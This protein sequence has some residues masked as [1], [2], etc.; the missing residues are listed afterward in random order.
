MN[1]KISLIALL[2]VVFTSFSYA[3]KST[4]DPV[5]MTI[6]GKP[7]TKSQFL[8]VYLKNNDHPKYDKK[9]LDKY[10]VLYKKFRLKVAEAEAEKYDTLPSLV[11]E[12]AKYRNELAQ[13]YL[14][15]TAKMH[16]LMHEAYNRMKQEVRASHIMIS[17]KPDASPEDTL[18]A[19]NKI[20]SIRKKVIDGA[21]FG[22][23]AQQ[24]SDDPSAKKNKGDLGYFSAFQMVY[25]FESAA[26]NTPIG[27]IS[28]PVRSRFGYHI[29]KVVAKRP[30]RGTI[31]VAHIMI[32]LAKGATKGEVQEANKKIDEIY[33]KLQNG[34]DFAKLAKLYSDDKSSKNNGGQ[35]APFG[36]G[37]NRRMVPVFEEMAYSLKKD[38]DYSKPFRSPY[39]F[40][41][42]KRIHLKPLGTYAELK[43][44]IKRKI[45]HDKRGKISKNVFIAQ[46]KKKNPFTDDSGKMLPWFYKNIDSTIFAKSWEAPKMKKNKTMFA[47]RG[48][49]YGSKAFLHYLSKHRFTKKI[50]IK[51]M[52]N[53]SYEKWQ[54]GLILADEKGRLTEEHPEYR[55]LMKEY[56]DGVLLYQIMKD[57]VW[58]KA[59]KDT[60]GLKTYFHNNIDKYQ[61]PNRVEATIYSSVDK[62]HVVEARKLAN[63]D[64]MTMDDVLKKVNAASQ[65]NLSAKQGKFIPSKNEV[66]KGRALKVGMGPIFKNGDKYYFVKVAK[67]IP[68]GA[69]K[70]DETRGIVIQDYQNYLEKNWLKKLSQKHTIKVNKDVLYSLGD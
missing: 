58:D 63:I 4:K 14:L 34:A 49:E 22:K 62:N 2:A 70:L 61:W 55:A 32:G 28:M 42:V 51:K 47:Y 66:L 50:P 30:A 21:D 20:M 15:D 31:T 69:K 67:K 46:L 48:K 45:D 44:Q 8:S 52:I 3:Q 10:M 68:A 18:K 7:I 27:K 12:L 9:T 65:L 13:P 36:T 59:L 26:Y 43:E 54:N 56:H 6:D 23:I 40:H 35:L 5:I 38:G 53:Q 57:K 24:Y 1:F 37:T 41:I 17:V 39:G 33:Q 60:S 11:S 16:Q 19:Y 64:T 25:P 29:L